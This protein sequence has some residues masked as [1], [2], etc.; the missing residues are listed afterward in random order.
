MPIEIKELHI[1]VTIQDTPKQSSITH[2]KIV[3]EISSSLKK[4][5]MQECV[6]RVLEILER[7][8]ED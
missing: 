1:K 5:I 4:E 2:E 3:E 7:K 6:E 8:F